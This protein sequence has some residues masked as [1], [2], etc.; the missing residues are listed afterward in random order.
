MTKPNR[1][2]RILSF[3]TV[4]VHEDK[5]I[6][7]FTIIFISLTFSNSLLEVQLLFEQK[8]LAN[9]HE[10]HEQTSP[11]SYIHSINQ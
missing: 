3:M 10:K 6:V 5:G 8:R 7:F 2:V 11:V 1:T 9:K 4:K